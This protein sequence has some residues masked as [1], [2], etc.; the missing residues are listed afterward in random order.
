MVHGIHMAMIVRSCI[1]FYSLRRLP[2]P[3]PPSP[4]LPSPSLPSRRTRWA[5]SSH[6]DLPVPTCSSFEKSA[7]R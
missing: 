2:P 1:Q 6:E 4:P 5:H 3:L 7:T